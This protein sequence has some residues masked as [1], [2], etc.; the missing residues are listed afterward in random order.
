[1]NEYLKGLGEL[2]LRTKWPLCSV[3]KT[4]CH[5]MYE[6]VF[7]SSEEQILTVFNSLRV[8]SVDRLNFKF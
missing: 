3:H 8:K 4:D 6:P 1:M 5:L 2:E 7:K